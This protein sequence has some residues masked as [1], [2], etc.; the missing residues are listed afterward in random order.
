MKMILTVFLG[1]ALISSANAY[2]QSGNLQDFTKETCAYR[3]IYDNLASDELLKGS[4]LS[5]I[6]LDSSWLTNFPFPILHHFAT[7]EMKAKNGLTYRGV[8]NGLYA[9]NEN[10]FDENKQRTGKTVTKCTHPY[11]IDVFNTAGDRIN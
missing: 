1:L 3:A 8:A 2:N 6:K 5:N 7:F 4:V 11:S 9:Y 10:E